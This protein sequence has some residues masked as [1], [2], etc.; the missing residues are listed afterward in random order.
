M[1]EKIFLGTYERRIDEKSR[2]VLPYQFRKA[3]NDGIIYQVLTEDSIKCYDSSFQKTIQAYLSRP[4]QERQKFFPR[5]EV[6]K[7]DK[8]GRIRLHH[9]FKK[10]ENLETV[11]FVGKGDFFEIK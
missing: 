3:L 9:Q 8:Q 7:I 6:T 1:N 11:L 2:V 10:D 5:I 4:I